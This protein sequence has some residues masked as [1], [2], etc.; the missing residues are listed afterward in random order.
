MSMRCAGCEAERLCEAHIMPNK[1]RAEISRRDFIKATT[2]LFGALIGALLGF[3]AIAYLIAPAVGGLE[4]S[5]WIKLGALE[6]YPVQVPT[7]AQFTRTSVNGWER[8]GMGYGVFVLRLDQASVRVFSNV[9]THLGCHVNW[10][11][12]LQHYVSPCHDGHFDILG[13]NVSGPPPRPLDEFVTRIEQG[14][15]YIRLPAYR[16]TS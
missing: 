10:H 6:T 3:P 4:D 2:G 1:Q 14:Q 5:G 16:R 12:E 7:L 9:C 8:T 13:K 15:L 11:P